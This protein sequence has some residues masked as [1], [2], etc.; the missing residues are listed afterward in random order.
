MISHAKLQQKLNKKQ[1]IKDRAAK[2]KGSIAII[3]KNE[4][5]GGVSG[6]CEITRINKHIRIGKMI[7][8]V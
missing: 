3:P 4:F 8:G 1:K 5:F 2:K 6:N 7:G